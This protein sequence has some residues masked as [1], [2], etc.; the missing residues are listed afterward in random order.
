MFAASTE[1]D[2]VTG[3]AESLFCQLSAFVYAFLKGFALSDRFQPV[4]D[5]AESPCRLR[6]THAA[7][8]SLIVNLPDAVVVPDGRECDRRAMFTKNERKQIFGLCHVMNKQG[9][10]MAGKALFLE[11]LYRFDRKTPG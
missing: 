5:G 10:D 6:E 4:I 2:E 7:N 9:C 3:V 8:V 1:D 11:F